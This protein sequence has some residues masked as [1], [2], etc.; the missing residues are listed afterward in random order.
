MYSVWDEQVIHTVLEE[1]L[2]EIKI[3]NLDKQNLYLIIGLY[4]LVYVRQ[5]CCNEQRDVFM[6]CVKAI[7]VASSNLA[8]K[9]AAISWRLV[10]IGEFLRESCQQPIFVF[11]SVTF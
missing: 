11:L 1:K 2:F 5:K 8:R 4:W 6:C 3:K 9:L 7:L 10:V